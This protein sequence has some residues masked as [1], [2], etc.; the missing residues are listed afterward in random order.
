MKRDIQA[1]ADREFDLVIAG[2]GIFGACAAWEAAS[3]GLSVAL[4]EQGDFLHST[5]GNHFRMVHGGVR[6]LQHA[7]IYRIR[8]SCFE[9]STFLRIAPHQVHP[10]PIIIPTYGHGMKGA[11]VLRAGLMVYDLLTLDRNRGIPDKKRHIPPGRI[12]SRQELLSMYPEVDRENLTGA[13]IFHDGQMHNPS[14]LGLCFIKSAVS[15]GAQAANYLEVRDFLK[16][17]SKVKGIVAYDRL[18]G[19]QVEIRS[20]MVLNTAGPW[21][22][23]LLREKMGAPLNPEPTFSRDAC[24]IVNRKLTEKYALTVL[25]RTKDPDAILSR[26]QRHLFIVPWQDVTLVGVWHVVHKGKPEDFTVTEED[27]QGFLDEINGAYAPLQLRLEDVSRWMAGLV[28]FGEKQEGG[29]NLSYGHRSHLID[30][31]REDQVDGLVTLLGVRATTARGMSEQAINLVIRKLGVKAAESRTAYTPIHGGEIEDFD[32]LVND[33]IRQRPRELAEESIPDLVHNHG[34]NYREVLR[35]IEDDPCWAEP[36]GSSRVVKA[37]VLHSVREEM[38]RRLSDVVIRR[39]DLG[40]GTH[41]GEAALKDCVQIMAKELGWNHQQ[42]QDELNEIRN[43][44]L[45][46][47]AGKG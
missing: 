35:Y 12:I 26:G 10:L 33:A 43:Y 27:L 32:R 1:L 25:G 29:E 4:V 38:A 19:D 24:F 9:R 44:Y 16:E 30:H 22:H 31:A 34:S 13:G 8:E 11:E 28:L 36:V 18:N 17:G 42:I 2:G 3:R 5:S 14:R 21:A 40:G 46:F 37:E 6:Y 47:S 15:A 23:H 20:R 7:D 39:T 45:N 41:P